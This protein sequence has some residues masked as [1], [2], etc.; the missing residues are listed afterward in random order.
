MSE[1]L[2]QSKE[3]YPGR[4]V[5]PSEKVTTLPVEDKSKRCVECAKKQTADHYFPEEENC[6][7]CGEE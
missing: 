5:P 2:K 1:E 7:E 6:G 4:E 3:G